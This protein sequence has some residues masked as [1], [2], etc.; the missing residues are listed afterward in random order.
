MASARVFRFVH[1]GGRSRFH[2]DYSKDGTPMHTHRLARQ[3]S[4]SSGERDAP[5][6]VQ[7]LGR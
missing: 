1:H 6:P 3:S 4:A 5:A 2:N 7:G